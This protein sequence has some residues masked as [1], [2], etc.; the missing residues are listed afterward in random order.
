[1][2]VDACA[3]VWSRSGPFGLLAPGGLVPLVALL[4]LGGLSIALTQVAFRVGP[5][6]AGF[7]ANLTADPVVA[8]VLGALL[9]GERVPT[10]PWHLAGYAVAVGLV[11]VGAVRLAA[12][13]ADAPE[14]R[15]A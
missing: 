13:S 9:L 7:P 6:V 12:G 4:V 1:V 2:L 14:A 3:A 11:V 5:L 15:P 10:D 8:V